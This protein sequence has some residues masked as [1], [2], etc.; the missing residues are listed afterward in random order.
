[1]PAVAGRSRQSKR[2]SAPAVTVSLDPGVRDALRFRWAPP[3]RTPDELV[4][5]DSVADIR[6]DASPAR[7]ALWLLAACTISLLLGI[8][9]S[10]D[11]EPEPP[12]TATRYFERRDADVYLVPVGTCS[13]ES[14]V[15][16][17]DHYEGDF[18]IRMGIA[19]ALPYRDGLYDAARKQLISEAVIAWM[20][21]KFE[22]HSSNA[23]AIFI[24]VTRN[25]IYSVTSRRPFIFEQRVPPHYAFVSSHRTR[26]EPAGQGDETTEVHPNLRKLVTRVIAALR[27]DKPESAN[28]RN[29]MYGPVRNID[30]L[31]A[32]DES[33]VRSVLTK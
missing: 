3:H 15:L 17:A 30:D 33:T 14:L 13:K 10:A 9:V 24:G 29:V 23:D 20:M 19:P 31:E 22:A 21:T 28:P 2:G 1:M 12:A 32:I 26:R 8:P 27:F 11:T 6:V 16:L 25:D 7:R 18:G 4:Q 5:T